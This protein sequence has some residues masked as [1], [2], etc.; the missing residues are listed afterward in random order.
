MCVGVCVCITVMV[1]SPVSP[2]MDGSSWPD[3]TMLQNKRGRHSTMEVEKQLD[4]GNDR[5][6]KSKEGEE[7]EL[8]IKGKVR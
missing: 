2:L 6:K 7:R 4:G 5:L 3:C 1:G 8:M